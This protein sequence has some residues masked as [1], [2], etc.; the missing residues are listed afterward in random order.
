MRKPILHNEKQRGQAIVLIAAVMVALIAALGLAIDGGG[1][2]LLYRDVQNATDSAA[3]TAAYAMCTGAPI[4]DSV[5]DNAR[6]NGFANGVRGTV[7]ITYPPPVGSMN[8][9]EI[10]IEATKPAYFIQIVYPGDL[11]VRASTTS[12]CQMGTDFGFPSSAAIVQLQESGC[13]GGGAA[14]LD[15]TGSSSVIVHGDIYINHA[16]TNCDSVELIDNNKA[17][18]YLNG[19][20]C[21]QGSRV[22]INHNTSDPGSELTPPPFTGGSSDFESPCNDVPQLTG[23]AALDPLGLASNPPSCAGLGSHGALNNYTTNDPNNPG[24]AQPGYYSDF[25]IN[26]N[27][28]VELQSGVYCFTGNA[29]IHGGLSSASGGVTLFQNCDC[30][31]KSNGQSHIDI[32]A[33]QSGDYRGLLIYSQ[34]TSTSNGHN[35]DGGT[36]ITMVGT[37]YS[38]QAECKITGGSSSILNAQFICYKF[39]IAGGAEVIIQHLPSL[40]YQVPPAFGVTQ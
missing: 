29:T 8:Y 7:T 23:T 31:I 5:Y 17:Q 2:F 32:E 20:M 36:D 22:S 28:H 16:S 21:V 1:L 6:Q 12:Q 37:V 40:V 13:G 3:L 39:F 14:P 34:S 26:S 25:S 30:T 33:Q 4:E 24:I 9:V 10:E 18:F 15:S 11:T 27:R 38:P 35:F 19:K